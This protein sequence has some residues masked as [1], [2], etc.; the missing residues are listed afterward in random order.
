M[1]T[2]W[3]DDL[4]SS[5]GRECCLRQDFHW[6][7]DSDAYTAVKAQGARYTV[8]GSLCITGGR[9]PIDVTRIGHP[10]DRVRIIAQYRQAVVDGKGHPLDSDDEWAVQGYVLCEGQW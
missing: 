10:E 5:K 9:D 8:P 1:I 2:A 3:A 6:W 4:A 7:Q